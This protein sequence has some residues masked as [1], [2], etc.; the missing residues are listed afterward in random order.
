MIT[1]NKN[2]LEITEG[3]PTPNSGKVL[4]S[5]S[6]TPEMDDNM[7]TSINK[8]LKSVSTSKAVCT[9][10]LNTNSRLSIEL[11]NGTEVALYSND[12]GDY[13]AV[14]GKKHE[15]NN[16]YSVT[17]K[18]ETN[19]LRKGQPSQFKVHTLETKVDCDNLFDVTSVQVRHFSREG[20]K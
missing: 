13:C 6:V 20:G 15:R 16:S 17:T 19:T 11:P 3:T 2:N 8:T 5:P 1:L 9:Y 7:N 10:R 14:L 18:E 12:N 4:S